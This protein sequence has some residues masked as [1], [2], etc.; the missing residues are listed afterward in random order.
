LIKNL[1]NGSIFELKTVLSKSFFWP[2]VEV[3]NYQNSFFDLFSA[4]V[5]RQYETF[6]LIFQ[7]HLG[8]SAALS[9]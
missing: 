4:T 3:K 2:K 9:I 5:G 1:Q 7:I 6:L 8:F